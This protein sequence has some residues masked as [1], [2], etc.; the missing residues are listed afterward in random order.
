MKNLKLP[1]IK[2]SHPAARCLSMDDYVKFVSLNLKYAIIDKKNIR[3]QKKL[4]MV[5]VPFSVE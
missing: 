2:E 3:R 5:N 1:I 4:A